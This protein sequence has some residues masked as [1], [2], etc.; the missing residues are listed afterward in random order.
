LLDQPN[1]TSCKA[2][3]PFSYYLPAIVVC[4]IY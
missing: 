2:T 3:Q 4:L 1:F